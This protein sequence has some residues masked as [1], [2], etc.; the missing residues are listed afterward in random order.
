MDSIDYSNIKFYESLGFKVGVEI[1]Q[2]LFTKKKMFCNCP[3]GKY[4][5]TY[6]AEILRHMRPT[7]SELGEYD[8]CALM[9]FKTKKEVIYLLNKESICTYEMD[10]TPPFLVNPEGLDIVIEI[11]LLLNCSIVDEMHI[12]RK[13]YLDGS[14]PTGFQR[15]AVVGINGWIPYKDRKIRISHIC[16]EE[17]ACREV[18]D[19]GHRI[20]FRTD[21][22]GIPLIEVITHPD[23]KTPQEAGDVV[24]EIGRLMRST[25]KVRRGI[26]SVRQDVNVSITGGNRVEIKGVPQIGWIPTLVHNEA[27]RQ[28]SLLEIKQIL[29][30]RNITEGNLNVFK[31]DLTNIFAST[32]SEILKNNLAKGAV[33]GGIKIGGLGGILNYPTQ[34]SKVFVDEIAGRV[35]VIAC[36]DIMPNL[37]NTDNYPSYED[38]DN[39]LA[40]IK[41]ALNIGKDDVGV[42]IWG[43]KQDVEAALE[44]VRLRIIDAIKGVPNETRQPF[45]SGLT[46]FERI[47]PGPNRMY[48]DTDSPPT[49]ITKETV[50]KI[51]Q[52]LP[53]APWEKEDDYIKLGIPCQVARELA[54]FGKTSLLYKI[55]ANNKL[56][57]TLVGVVLTQQ[58]KA[59]RRKGINV[60]RISDEATLE[61]FELYAKGA[62]HKEAIPLIIEKLAEDGSLSVKDII[63]KFNL[64]VIAEG[65]L[66]DVVERTIKDNQFK[67]LKSNQKNLLDKMTKF[68]VGKVM[69]KF[70]GRIN[71]QVLQMYVRGRLKK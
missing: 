55:L 41:K 24:M 33:I 71:G 44:E 16:Y 40:L 26:G 22:L 12:S 17:D 67:I 39:D 36:L 63:A 49:T 9:E 58:L 38:S 48:P 61:L 25:G 5:K 68:Y 46:D 23:M 59:L 28:K 10:D 54:I 52:C 11:A 3:T 19:I 4:S 69:E 31:S 35:R 14:I 21:R 42:I 18:S 60:N 8:G 57:P 27:L 1:H 56:N 7:L 64:S 20:T 43:S 29:A 66:Q 37:F 30:Q 34:P 15:T 32:K 6:D 51:K 50:E 70:K 45:R 2:Q 62:F 47:L 13:Q 65:K 53:K